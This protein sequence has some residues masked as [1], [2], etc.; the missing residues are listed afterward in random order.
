MSTLWNK[1]QFK[2]VIKF[3]EAYEEL[4]DY[5]VST[6]ARV[7]TLCLVSDLD[8]DFASSQSSA[9]TLF[10][11]QASSGSLTIFDYDGLLN[12][13][14]GL[15]P[16]FGYMTPGLHI[17]AY[18][19]DYVEEIEDY[20]WED[21]GEWFVSDWQGGMENGGITAVTIGIDDIL[22][23]ISPVSLDDVEYNGVTAEDAL[24]AALT[25]AGIDEDKFEIDSSLDLNFSYTSLLTNVAMTINDILTLSIGY[26]TVGHDGVIRFMS[27]TA[28]AAQAEEH[29]VG[30]NLGAL[31]SAFSSG[32][33][34]NKI[35]V[36]YPNGSNSQLVRA[37]HDYATVVGN[38]DTNVKLDLPAGVLSI[39]ALRTIL[40]NCADED[41]L[42]DVAYVKAGDTLNIT[43]N[44]DIAEDTTR[45][46][47]IDVYVTTPTSSAYNEHVIDIDSVASNNSYSYIYEA[48]YTTT[49]SAAESIANALVDIIRRM[50]NQ[51]SCGTSLLSP[52]INVGDTL[53]IEDVSDEYDGHYAIVSLSITMGSTYNTS[54]KLLKYEEE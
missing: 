47:I 18:I 25:A 15:S 12:P 4:D 41:K 33:N 48:P 1:E 32:L 21:Y 23:E 13:L 5:V 53:I 7:S 11:L 46:C 34:Y 24:I 45:D 19:A 28:A 38:G 31:A 20:V 54:I 51:V 35:I 6:D 14:N 17:L 29:N 3:S 36:R 9:S 39:E 42:N 16:Y 8:F 10:T 50:R 2:F 40:K 22:S 49:E 52:R 37:I 27:L 30:N 26:C 43:I 44:A